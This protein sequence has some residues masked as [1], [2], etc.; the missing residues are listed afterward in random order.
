MI[1]MK[2]QNLATRPDFDGAASKTNGYVGLVIHEYTTEP[3]TSDFSTYLIRP[4][5]EVVWNKF[6]DGE[7]KHV[8]NFAGELLTGELVQ[9]TLFYDNDTLAQQVLIQELEGRATQA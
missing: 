2:W 8:G 9:C 1:I 3:P 4:V 5:N 7:P 6:P